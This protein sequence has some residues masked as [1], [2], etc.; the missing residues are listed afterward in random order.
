MMVGSF[1]HGALTLGC[2]VIGLRFVRFWRLTRDPFFLC[3]AV[4]FGLFAVD[5]TLRTFVTNTD[6]TYLAFLPRLAGFLTI[7][8][9]IAIKN[10]TPSE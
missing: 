4:A 10:R 6:A 9:A 1:L 5:W 8:A 2:F 3:F 7:I